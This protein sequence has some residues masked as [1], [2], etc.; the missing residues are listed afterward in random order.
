[1][2]PVLRTPGKDNR[3]VSETPMCLLLGM[4]FVH[5]LDPRF[6]VVQVSEELMKAMGLI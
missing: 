1:M 3:K 6:L 2:E 5:I 4:F